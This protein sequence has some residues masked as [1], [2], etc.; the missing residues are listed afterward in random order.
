MSEANLEQKIL[1]PTKRMAELVR[2]ACGEH[3][4]RI[5]NIWLN[6]LSANLRRT[7]RVS[8]LSASYEYRLLVKWG[9]I[10]PEK[11]SWVQ[12]RLWEQEH[13]ASEDS[14]AELLVSVLSSIAEKA[15]DLEE[16]EAT[17]T[18]SNTYGSARW[19]EIG[20]FE[21]AGYIVNR[22][23]PGRLIIGPAGDGRIISVDRENTLKHAMMIGPT[24]S[25]KSSKV[26]KAR[27]FFD[28][29]SR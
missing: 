11:S 12:A 17:A 28:S 21:K 2:T 24:G 13:R 27:Q 20:D 25:G 10:I 4:W 6:Q 5:E 23:E 16:A 29:K 15:S 18:P 9:E 8:G 7:Q 1:A 22:P 14:L 26:I 3:G 19:A